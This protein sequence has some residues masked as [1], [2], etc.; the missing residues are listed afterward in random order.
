MKQGWIWAL[1]AALV[2]AIAIGVLSI[3]VVLSGGHDTLVLDLEAGD[4]FDMPADMSQATITKVD[5][6]DCTDPHGAE[7]IATGQL[8]PDRDVPYPADNVLFSQ[9]DRECTAAIAGQSDVADR[10]GV[11][12]VVPNEKSWD[13]YRG[14]YVC[15]AIPYGGGT[16]TGG[17][18]F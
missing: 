15:V 1:M 13:S 11:L 18:K 2:V 10:F 6:I 7:V 16:T 9:A 12:P 8:N 4:C 17:L 5:T 3:V 14:R